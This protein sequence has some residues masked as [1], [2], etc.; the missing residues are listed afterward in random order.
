QSILLPD[1]SI[2]EQ[3]HTLVVLTAEGQVYQGIVVDKDDRRVV[4]KESTGAMRTVPIDSIEEQKAGGSLMPKGLVNLMT[5]AEC[6]DLVRSLSERGNPGPNAI[7]TTPTI[8]RWRVLKPV[9]SGLPEGVPDAGTLP[10]EVLHAAPERWGTVYARVS[11][12][13]PLNE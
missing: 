7:R 5:H 11:G 9:S 13:L 3:F 10:D 12:A 8:Q 6:L 1:Q 2:K 4:L